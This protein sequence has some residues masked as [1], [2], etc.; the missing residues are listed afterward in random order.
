MSN[1]NLEGLFAPRDIALIGASSQAGSL[2]RVVLANVIRGGYPGEIYVVNPRPV[3]APGA[4]WF[5]DIGDL[6]VAPDLAIVMTPPKTVPEVIRELAQRGTKLAVVLTAGI[7]AES[8]LRA[9]MIEAARDGGIRIIG[10]NCLGVLMPHARLDASFSRN[11]AIPGRLALI[12]QSGA[13]VTAVLDYAGQRDVGFS[14][15]VCAGDMADTD[16]ADLIDL[17]GEDRHTDAILLCIESVGDGARFMSAARAAACHKPIIAIKEGSGEDAGKAALSHSGALAGSCEVYRA[18]F[19]RAGIVMVSTL[20]ELFDAAEILCNI[21]GASGEKIAI[22]TNGGGASVLAVDEIK[23]NGHNLATLSSTT[24]DSLDALLPATWSHANP[25]DLMGDGGEG[26]YSAVMRTVLADPQV[27]TVL[28]IYCPTAVVSAA[29]V[30]RAV[31]DEALRALKAGHAKPVIAC[32][33]GGEDRQARSILRAASIPVF[34]TPDAAVQGLAYL[35]AAR[36]SFASMAETVPAARR[37]N[38]DRPAGGK[39]ISEARTAGRTFLNEIEAKKLL[40][41]YNIPVAPTHFARRSEDVYDAC[42]GLVPPYALKVVSPD[43]IHKAD[44]GGVALSLS[45]PANV[46]TSALVMEERIRRESPEARIMG[47]AVQSMCVRLNK[48]ELLIGIAN[49]PTFG[50]VILFGAGGKA[51]EVLDDVAVTLP[52]LD[53]KQA[54]ALI[55]RTRVADVINGYGDQPAANRADLVNALVGLSRLLEDFPDIIE[56][57]VNPLICDPDGV[58]ALDARVVI[59]SKPSPVSGLVVRPVPEQW[60][61]DLSTRSGTRLHIRP[62]VP[63]DDELL[64]NFFADVTPD[65]LRFRFLSSL[66]HVEHQHIAAMTRV[67]YHRTI[68]FLALEPSGAV[69]AT[70]MLAADSDRNRA[71][72]AMSTRSGWKGKGVS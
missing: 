14:G 42:I 1:R 49:D 20:S 58:M 4:R 54:N 13:L 51:A 29:A 8:G 3:S 10:P 64:A 59:S 35:V 2:G 9:K 44:V 23:R 15:V 30:A 45:S 33:F 32:W 50:P 28:V 37:P 68:T 16:I 24:I 39:I 47:F 38:V 43:I 67:D 11:S 69:V 48:V 12:S 72:I 53:E 56:L 17:F 70:A 6:P 21:E 46:A 7:D 5:A 63:S 18:A 19:D 65:D 61:T 31:A 52:P 34:A 71:E 62:A 26:R 55:D 60:A 41:A 57:D 66:S 22:V 40:K 36:R 25:I 27:H